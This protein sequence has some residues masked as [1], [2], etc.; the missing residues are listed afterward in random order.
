MRTLAAYL[1]VSVRTI[2]RMIRDRRFPPPT[3][4]TERIPMWSTEII[5][6]WCR[7]EWKPAPARRAK[8]PGREE[9]AC[10]ASDDR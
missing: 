3:C 7:G 6:Q 9:V 4:G 5:D 10:A 2:K 1:E 8:A